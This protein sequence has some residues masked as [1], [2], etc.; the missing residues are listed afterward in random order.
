LELVREFLQ[1][2]RFRERVRR[3][4][5]NAFPETDFGTVP[6][7]LMLLGLL[8][9]GGR[10]IWHLRYV[11]SDPILA[12]FAGL[13]RLPSTRT[14]S[15]WLVRLSSRHVAR[16]VQLNSEVV[17][18]ALEEAALRRLTIDVDGSVV[19]TGQRVQGAKRGFNPHRR[20]VPSYYPITAYE[21]QSGQI[22]RVENR[23][24]NVHDGKASLD[25]LEALVDQIRETVDRRL[26]L[27]FRMDGAFF[28]RDVLAFLDS[29]G[30][31]YA[32]KVPF[33]PW[34]HL[35]TAVTLATEWT[36]IDEKVS[37]CETCT[38]VAP[39]NQV[40]RIVLYRK[41]VAHETRKNF[42][43]D[44]FDPDDGHYEYS[45]ITTNK[46]LNGLNLW[47][48][49]NGR[50]NHEKAYAELRNGFAFNCVPSLKAPANAAWQVLSVLAFNLTRSF[51]V[52]ARP[53]PRS[54]SRKRRTLH[55]FE[56]IH[57]LRFKLLGRAGVLLHPAGR[58]TL[59]L[60][61]SPAAQLDFERTA[62]A[63]RAA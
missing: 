51:Q 25:F 54:R 23:P 1:V 22:L 39:W 34:L 27:E 2:R 59:D 21:A 62:Q 17:G 36:R 12:R 9:V 7:L 48:F 44:L 37:F 32:V 20:K 13:R 61:T 24:G 31:E 56:T 63:L 38:L 53:Q 50:G 57:T 19:S 42:Q 3:V 29:V 14:V 60:G 18:E 10:R 35:K 52:A 30:A 16:L 47:H 8:M 43:L 28:R 45:A 11:Q 4:V 49:L 5:G 15:G 46:A 58:I 55:R 33:Y 40:H 26:R 6:M 41:R